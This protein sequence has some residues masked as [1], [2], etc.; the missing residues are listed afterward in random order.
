MVQYIHY[1]GVDQLACVLYVNDTLV[2]RAG[3]MLMY[4]T[5]NMKLLFLLLETLTRLILLESRE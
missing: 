2:R 1:T 3:E 5:N 4:T